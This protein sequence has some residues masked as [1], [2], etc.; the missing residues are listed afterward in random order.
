MIV[1]HISLVTLAAVIVLA[2]HFIT[3]VGEEQDAKFMDDMDGDDDEDDYFP[4]IAMIWWF[5]L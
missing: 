4:I 1:A 2:C 5:W 3:V